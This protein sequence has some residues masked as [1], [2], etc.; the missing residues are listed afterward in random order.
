[1]A[2]CQWNVFLYTA[3]SQPRGLSRV[4]SLGNSDAVTGL[5][6]GTDHLWM[7]TTREL[8]Y[9]SFKTLHV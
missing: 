5:A 6:A 7:S 3:T 8:L 2:E 4:V 9:V 1:M